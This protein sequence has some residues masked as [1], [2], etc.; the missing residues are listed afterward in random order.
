MTGD[1]VND[2]PALKAADIGIAMGERGTDVA[3]EAAALVLLDDSFASIV[4]AIRQGRIIYDNIS[5]AT[6][7]VFAVHMPI[8]LL[9]LAPTLL[10]WPVL[11][12]PVHIVLME[13]LIDPACSIVFEAEP[14]AEGLM[15]RPPRQPGVTPFAR[16]NLRYGVVQGLGFATLLL[17]GCAALLSLGMGNG[18][19]RGAEF[20]AL[21]IGVFLLTLS[22]R[23]RSRALLAWPRAGNP[24]LWRMFAGVLLMLVAAFAIAPM[25]RLL[26]LAPADA[27]IVAAAAAMIAATGLW[28]E[29]WRRI[30]GRERTAA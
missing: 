26:A 18:A 11:L 23:S 4:A 20:I 19:V 25:R 3:R 12:T 28:L 16:A 5:K 7:F 13:L 30:T 29:G 14:P 24:W 22:A 8:V 10:H 15:L 2:A 1:G 21:V 6:R 9:A 27:A 17:A